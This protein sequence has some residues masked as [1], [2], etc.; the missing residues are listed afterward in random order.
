LHQITGFGWAGPDQ[1]ASLEC[2]LCISERPGFSFLLILP[3]SLPAFQLPVFH[4]DDEEEEEKEKKEE[5]L[6][7][8]RMSDKDLSNSLAFKSSAHRNHQDNS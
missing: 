1:I 5:L 7:T 4:D 3:F 8:V 2:P 6:V